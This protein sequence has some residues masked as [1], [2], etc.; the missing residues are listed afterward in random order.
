MKL[1]IASVLLLLLLLSNRSFSQDEFSGGSPYTVFGIGD[2]N[3]FT[4]ARTYAMG[5]LGIS[6]FGNYVNN[7]NPAAQTKLNHTMASTVFNYGFLKSTDGTTDNKVSNGNV[8]GINIGIPFNQNNGWVFTIGFNPVSLVNYKIRVDNQVNGQNYVQ[9]Y[10]GKGGLSR[11][12]ASMTYILFK[13]ISAGFEYNYAFGEI[14]TRNSIVFNASGFTNTE[15]TL[16][17]DMYGN[18][19]KGGL[20]FDFGKISRSSALRNLSVGFIYESNIKLNSDIEAIY[21]TSVSIDSSVIRRGVLNIPERYGFGI[22]N[23]FGDRYMV[24]ADLIMQDWSKY[25]DYGRSFGNFGTSVRAGVG[26]DILPKGDPASFWSHVSYRFG[27]FYDKAYYKVNGEDIISYGLSGGINLPL[28]LYN[29][30]DLGVTAGMRG[31]TGN[32][33]IKDEFI[34]F[35]A[36]LNL[37][38]LWFIRT[39]DEDR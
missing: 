28:S 17:N 23:L 2:I 27:G 11:I 29:S 14:K 13:A 24:T 1:R 3:Y 31:K 6:L 38:E 26:I 33:L 8:T 16:E 39:R 18:M 30:L 15:N 37:G 36:G 10:S 20:V 9:T 19:F 5:S 34:S 7:L 21:Q 32:S 12:N 25:T 4:S 35:T 22:S